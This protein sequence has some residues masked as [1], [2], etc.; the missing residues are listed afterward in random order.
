M[1]H[2][3]LMLYLYRNVITH[4]WCAFV[5]GLNVMLFQVSQVM[6]MIMLEMKRGNLSYGIG[7]IGYDIGA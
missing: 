4:S 7:L 6:M 5:S 2:M 1:S 3:L